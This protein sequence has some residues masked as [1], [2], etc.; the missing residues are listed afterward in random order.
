[1][2]RPSAGGPSAGAPGPLAAVHRLALQTFRVLPPRVRF[3]IVRRTT[4]QFTVG[5]VV[6]LQRGDEILVLRQRHHHGWTLPGGLL[7]RGETPREALVRELDE[8]LALR[9]DVP[10]D[11]TAV[12]FQPRFRHID[13]VFHLHL[14][15]D[16][17][18]R[19]EPDG[20]EVLD[21]AWRRADDPAIAEV[22]LVALRRVPG[23]PGLTAAG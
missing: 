19:L 20:T 23:L 5:T 11:P 3:A 15:E 1:M 6:A 17:R 13:A 8:E 16:A 4:P 9:L 7:D 12:V 22:A 18:P 14:P 2:Q 10:E 21:V